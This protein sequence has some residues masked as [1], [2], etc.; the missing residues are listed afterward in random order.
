MTRQVQ[1]AVVFFVLAVGFAPARA[2]SV[3]TDMTIAKTD[4]ASIYTAGDTVTYTITAGNAGPDTASSAKVTDSVSV[5]PQYSTATWT[6]IAA[7]GATCTAGPVIGDISDT[8]TLPVGGTVTYT[9]ALKTTSNATG[10]LVNTATIF[11]LPGTTTDPDLTGNTAIDTDT[12]AA[13]LHVDPNGTDSATCGPAGTACKTIQAAINNASADNSVVVSAGTY[14]E[15]ITV[16]PGAGPGGILVASNEFLSAGTATS[17]IIDG[18]GVCDVAPATPGP[19]VTIHDK[20]IIKGFTISHGGD[21]GVWG[22]GAAV[23]SHN[24]IADNKTPGTGGGVRLTTGTYLTDPEAGALIETNTIRNNVSVLGGAGIFVTATGNGVPSVVRIESNAITT[25]TAGDG[26]VGATGGGIA[27]VSD[28]LSASDRS[29]V[30]ITKNTLDGNVAKNVT[31]NASIAYGGGIFVST[32]GVF[33]LGT[34]TVAI[35][36]TGSGNIIR[37]G[38]SEGLGGGISVRTQPSPS[39]KGA[40]SVEAN[41]ISANIGKRGGGGI[42]LFM[43]AFDRVA[44]AL[45]DVVVR[46]AGNAISGNRAQGSLDDPIA[47]GGGG[48]YAELYAERTVA[49]AVRF[50]ISGNTIENNF[51]TTHGGGVSLLAWADDDPENDGATAPTEAGISFHN[52][53]IDKNSAT[54]TTARTPSGGGAVGRVVARGGTAVARLTHDFLTVAGNHTELGTGGI[55]WQDF[56]IANSLGLKGFGVFTLSNSVIT[57]NDGYGLGASLPLDPTTTVTISYTD[58]YGNI[59][60]NYDPQLG[61]PTGTNGNISIDPELDPLYLPRL[62]GPVI[63]QGDPLVPATNEAQPNGGRVNL[64]HLGNTSSATRTFPDVNG[65]GTIDGLDLLGVA[66]SFN[67]CSDLSCSDHSRYFLAADRDLNNRVDGDDLSYVSAF[68]SQSCP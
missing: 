27:V 43:H 49:A 10:N 42:H 50:E 55:E 18:T 11:P 41:T 64:G 28:T 24:V 62:C 9:L 34:E 45:P 51:T 12:P 39:G 68:Y 61:D 23:I 14:S 47:V 37:N 63:D 26:S 35:G 15:C 17:T 67:S 57:G 6:C 13:I 4:H 20:S 38:T 44:G 19:V 30:S 46:A 21:S 32:G 53:L 56:R 7:G 31:G 40:V 36:A 5:R 3:T 66:V 52:N 8:V 16:A 22:L 25:N 48:I 60:G 2:G 1:V 29:T 58:N 33:G 54:D 59:S 65:D